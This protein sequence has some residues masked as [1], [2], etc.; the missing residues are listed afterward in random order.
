M[1]KAIIII[2]YSILLGQIT[3]MPQR[4]DLIQ[5]ALLMERKGDI[6]RARTLY[7]DMLRENPGNRQAYQRLKEILKR[8]GELDSAAQLVEVWID[9]NPNDLQAYIELGEIVFLKKDK[10]SAAKI[11]HDFEMTYGTNKSIY[12]MLVHAFSRLGLTEE[13]ERLV[14][15]GRSKLGQKDMLALDL[16]N[17]YYSRQTYDRA[18]DEYLI[19]IIEHPQ[20][21]KLVTD[22][23]LLMSDDPENHLLIE[24]KLIS[25]LENN[26]LI[27][28]K[29]LAGYYFKTSRYNEALNT[30]RSMGLDKNSDFNRWLLLAANLRKE[31][32]YDLS[33]KAYQE[34]LDLEL[35]IPAKIIG[36]ALLGLGKTY[37]DQLLPNI[38]N[39]LLV[40]FY[41]DNLFFENGFLKIS[42]R[43][44]ESLEKTF[45][46]YKRVLQELPASSFS[47]K[48]HFRLGEIQFK[49]TRDFDGARA[50]Y[51]SALASRPDNNLR[52]NILLR[53]GDTFI[54]E[55]NLIAARNHFKVQHRNNNNSISP[56]TMKEIQLTF[57]TG[58][59]DT[60]K[61]VL[62]SVIVNS[63]PNDK[64][65]NDLMELQD[66][67]AQHY[68]FGSKTDKEALLQYSIAERFL[69]Q[70]K[71]V[72]AAEM[73]A[74]IRE[75][76]PDVSILP[77][78]MLRECLLRLLLEDVSISLNIAQLLEKTIFA[79]QGITIQGE[80]NE[81]FF[82]DIDNAMKFYNNLLE[83][84]PMSM[85][86]E[87]V[88]M[89][90]RQLKTTE[91]S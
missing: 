63:L 28:N 9:L 55:G 73:L 1:N 69:Q 23:V 5:N 8:T 38:P 51:L 64:Y 34:L 71:L 87:P 3:V 43:S 17:Y 36:E 80:I 46:L 16:A 4:R 74:F 75:N 50:S 12:R 85:L 59:I 39:N 48:A 84:Y 7:E 81:Q 78:V 68:T 42:S 29:L 70:Y 66:I 19:Y 89:R 15:R 22:R 49:I 72:E 88:R 83:S 61:T 45:E 41:P 26:H 90:M 14:K 86:A 58:T 47:P 91:E 76:Y 31:S 52:E 24:K 79:P 44:R 10:I 77:T 11:W 56:F 65:F 20:Q 32:Q 33:I 60:A 21:E 37:E 2:S 27:I 30:H 6:E 13:M 62:D 54:A 25:S 57:L 82:G 18:L 35:E 67:I 53:I 40:G